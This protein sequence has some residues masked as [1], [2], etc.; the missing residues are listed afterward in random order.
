MS[1]NMREEGSTALVYILIDTN[2]QI[3]GKQ[4]HQPDNE[5]QKTGVCHFLHTHDID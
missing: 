1:K 4:Q 2:Y 3:H 5:I